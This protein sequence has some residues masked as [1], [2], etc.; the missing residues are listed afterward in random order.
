MRSVERDP[1][2]LDGFAPDRPDFYLGTPEPAFA[3][4]R[5]HDPVHWYGAGRFWCLTRHA[6]IREVSRNPNVFSSSHGLQMWQIPVVQ[7]GGEIEAA[8][9]DGAVSILEMD[10]PRHQAHRLLVTSAFRPRYIDHLSHRIREIASAALDACPPNDPIDFVEHIAVPLP[11]LVI[12]EMI[13]VP[14][15]DL[16]TFRKWSD[17]IIAAGSGGLTDNMLADLADLYA[18]FGE[19]LTEHRT[20]PRDDLIT[21]LIDAEVDGSHLSDDEILV[22][23][24]TLL[25]AGNETTRNLISGSAL[26]LALHPGQ[27][28]LLASDPDVLPVAVEEMLRWVSPVRSFIRRALIN[29]SLAEIP[30][31]AGDYVV[32]FYGSA[33]RDQAVFGETAERFDVTRADAN[34]HLAFGIGEHF[35]LGAALARMETRILFE[36]IYRRWPSWELNGDVQPLKSCLINGIERLPLRRT[37]R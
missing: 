14:T 35:C 22:F 31:R 8:G 34:R 12:A 25:V 5:E 6:E 11:M 15:G 16:Q 7:A 37:T 33:N 17:S 36:E 27:N 21:L 23:L 30:I 4:L 26:A 2:I 9:T 3:H 29:T 10:P 1:S 18:Y 20:T 13:G 24:M 32:M 28:A 19:S